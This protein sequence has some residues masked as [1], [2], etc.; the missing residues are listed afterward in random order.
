[1][2]KR[3][4]AHKSQSV[5]EDDFAVSDHRQKDPEVKEHHHRNVHLGDMIRYLFAPLDERLHADV[6][7]ERKFVKY[8]VCA[9]Y[10]INEPGRTQPHIPTT[11]I[12]LF[13]DLIYVATTVRFTVNMADD[14]YAHP[15][16]KDIHL[17][18]MSFMI[19]VFFWLTTVEITTRFQAIGRAAN[20]L[21]DLFWGGYMFGVIGIAVNC[22]FYESHWYKRLINSMLFAS[23]FSSLVEVVFLWIPTAYIHTRAHLAEKFVAF[24]ICLLFRLGLDDNSNVD[25]MTAFFAIWL[26]WKFLMPWMQKYFFVKKEN[27]VPLNIARFEDRYGEFFLVLIGENFITIMTSQVDWDTYMSYR[28]VGGFLANLTA[29]NLFYF[30]YK[31]EDTKYHGFARNPY[32]AIGVYI[33]QLIIYLGLLGYGVGQKLALKHFAKA[34]EWYASDS[35][36]ATESTVEYPN[37]SYPSD[38][39]ASTEYPSS[40]SSGGYDGRRFLGPSSGYGNAY[41]KYAHQLDSLDSKLIN[42]SQLCILLGIVIMW[43]CNQA[44]WHSEDLKRELIPSFAIISAIIIGPLLLISYHESVSLEE[45]N[46]TSFAIV[47]FAYM[48]SKFMPQHTLNEFKAVAAGSHGHG[49]GHEPH[50]GMKLHMKNHRISIRGDAEMADL[51]DLQKD[52]GGRTTDFDHGDIDE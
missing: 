3:D 39:Y 1:M 41:S 34:M 49:H 51:G 28:L 40:E 32:T 11:P 10:Q 38:P 13:F 37:D 20:F 45:Q 44:G 25:Y 15:D 47:T 23:C 48:V 18:Y 22:H 16:G 52:Y 31:P 6:P 46:W 12:E 33:A 35:S 8:A 26:S 2:T 36:A 17:Y 7:E 27:Y 29:I 9:C 42:Y 4:A 14:L 5:Q 24:V 21:T 50:L 43:Y 30:D 19:L